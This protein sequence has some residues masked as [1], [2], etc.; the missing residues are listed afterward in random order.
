MLKTKQA[1][2][3]VEKAKPEKFSNDDKAVKAIQ[4]AIKKG[5][6]RPMLLE[7]SASDHKA[8]SNLAFLKATQKMVDLLKKQGERP[9]QYLTAQQKEVLEDDELKQKLKEKYQR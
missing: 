4:D 8:S 9:D 2:E 6:S 3:K 1:K 7:Q 5:R